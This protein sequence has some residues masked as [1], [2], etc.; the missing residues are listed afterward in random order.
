MVTPY[1]PVVNLTPPG[2][3]AASPSSVVAP[4]IADPFQYLIDNPGTEAQRLLD[5]TANLPIKPRRENGLFSK[6]HRLPAD[7]QWLA[8]EME[9]IQEQLQDA[10]L[11]VHGEVSIYHSSVIECALKHHKR[12]RLLERWLIRPEHVNRTRKNDPK[13]HNTTA[14]IPLKNRVVLVK[15]EAQAADAR[16]KAIQLLGLSKSDRDDSPN[17]E[18]IFS[19]GVKAGSAIEAK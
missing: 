5:V 13:G 11:Q 4:L 2:K 17:W 1:I 9:T 10:V 16:A 14:A 15:Q 6:L 18:K 19:L 7:C 8:V 12:Q 3:P